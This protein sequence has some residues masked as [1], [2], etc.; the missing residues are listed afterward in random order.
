MIHV[1]LDGQVAL[2]TGAARGIGAAVARR[3]AACGA[4]VVVNDRCIDEAAEGVLQGIE[5][6]G[7]RAMAVQADV[8]DATE[9]EAMFRT[10]LGEYD[11]IDVLVNNAGIVK[12]GLLATLREKDWQRVI[13]VSLGGAY[14]C[15]R[16]AIRSMMPARRGRV[17]NMASIRALRGGRGQANYAAAKAGLVAFTRATALEV[18]QHG[19]RVNAVLPG[20]ID[21]DMTAHIKR[22][23]GDEVLKHIP[24]GRLGTP[25]DVA[26]VVA[27]L[28]SDD[29]DY[30]TGQ[31]FVVD[32]GLT[33]T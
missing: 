21:T 8:T 1:D 27:F 15:T 19:I 29:A 18:A 3:L 24:V 22:R 26:G 11:R 4:T 12:D 30:V 13:D 7:G 32:G 17:V 16:L 28:C 33:I 9:V 5:A 6:G 31:A 10:V 25:E 2:V 20:F 23:A 14:R